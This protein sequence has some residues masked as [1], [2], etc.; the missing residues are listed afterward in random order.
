MQLRN[1]LNSAC[2]WEVFAVRRPGTSWSLLSSGGLELDHQL[3]GHPSEV[4]HLDALRLGP[5]ANL[6]RVQAVRRRFASAPDWP[7][8]PTPGP[9]RRLHVARQRPPQRLDMSGFQVDLV[10]CAVQAEADRALAAVEVVDDQGLY[11]L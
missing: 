9:A 8:R 10:I 11:L 5:L 3:G 7:P 4:L 2:V 1:V 6:G